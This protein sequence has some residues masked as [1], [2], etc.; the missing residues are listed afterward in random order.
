MHTPLS[1]TVDGEFG[2]DSSKKTPLAADGHRKRV[3]SFLGSKMP[4]VERELGNMAMVYGGGDATVQRHGNDHREDLRSFEAAVMARKRPTTLAAKRPRMAR[5]RSGG[6]NVC[7][8]SLLILRI[9]FL[10]FD[11][12]PCY[13]SR[14]LLLKYVGSAPRHLQTCHLEVRTTHYTYS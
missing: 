2:K 9:P 5:G 13:F 8:C 6:V 4:I 11:S 3:A 7:S 14:L 10:S 12:H 1:D